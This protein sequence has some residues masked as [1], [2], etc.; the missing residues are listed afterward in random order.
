MTSRDFCYWLQGVFEV[1]DPTRLDEAATAKIKA[2]LAL[3][4]AHE[5]D[6]SMGDKS[7]Q[8]LL[9]AIHDQGFTGTD[10]K[11]HGPHRPPGGPTMRC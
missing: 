8:D 11:P 4:F 10:G 3:V 5:L 1:A 9:N 7:K 2:H 6:P